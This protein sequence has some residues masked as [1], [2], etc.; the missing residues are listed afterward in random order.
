MT[1]G[2][3]NAVTFVTTFLGG[4]RM[5]FGKESEIFEFKESTSELHQAIESIDAILNKHGYEKSI[6][7]S[8]R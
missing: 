3:T 5:N 4:C 8:F 2:V 7:W 6:I 1:L